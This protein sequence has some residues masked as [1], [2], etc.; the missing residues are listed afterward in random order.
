MISHIQHPALLFPKP[1]LPTRSRFRRMG[2]SS[3]LSAAARRWRCCKKDG[4]GESSI[5]PDTSGKISV[6]QKISSSHLRAAFHRSGRPAG[7]RTV[8]AGAPASQERL[9]KRGHWLQQPGPVV[10]ALSPRFKDR[11]KV[12]SAGG[13]CITVAPY[14]VAMA[15]VASVEPESTSMISTSCIVCRRT[16]SSSRP[17][18]GS[19]LKARM[20]REQPFI[21]AYTPFHQ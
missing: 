6:A 17:I 7:L 14:C 18:C 16:P 8:R 19:S 5:F 11:P 15:D 20:I 12:N 1:G 3:I 2:E 10:A 21:C 13:M 4:F 9:D